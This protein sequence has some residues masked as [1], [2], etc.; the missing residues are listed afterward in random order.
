MILLKIFDV[1]TKVSVGTWRDEYG[2]SNIS[3]D[4]NISKTEI[5]GDGTKEELEI[6]AH[7]EQIKHKGTAKFILLNGE[8]LAVDYEEPKQDWVGSYEVG[9]F[10]GEWEDVVVKNKT[11]KEFIDYMDNTFGLGWVEP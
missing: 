9:N 1:P 10:S 8:T 7:Q 3:K 5:V 11:R 4:I 2:S 6:L